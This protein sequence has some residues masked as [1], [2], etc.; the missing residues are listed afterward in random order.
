V[1]ARIAGL[2]EA[3]WMTQAAAMASDQTP[4]KPQRVMAALRRVLPP[5]AV[6]IADAGTP[7]P[8]VSAFLD[9]PEPGRQVIIPRAYGGLGY[10]IPAV[11]GAALARPGCTV[12]GLCG[13]GSFG[14]SAGELETLGRLGLPV[15]IVN[16][17]N[18]SFG[19]IKALQSIHSDERYLGVDFS[20]SDHAAIA[21]AS[22]MH[23]ITVDAAADLED[24]LSRALAS[25]APTLVDVSTESEEKDL[26][27]VK[28]WRNVAASK[29]VG[30][31]YIDPEGGSSWHE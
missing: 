5:D 15:M 27:P 22:G 31:G 13:D 6:V 17:S 16:F 30:S 3:W 19:W 10:A 29:R 24:A 23:G 25:G 2:R 4:I 26:P 14:M 18:R 11:V 9:I 20:K 12:V 1:A 28:S 8:Y 7:T 21:R